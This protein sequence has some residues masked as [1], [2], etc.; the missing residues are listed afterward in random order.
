MHRTAVIVLF[1]GFYVRRDILM[2]CLHMLCCLVV[3]TVISVISTVILSMLLYVDS[4]AFSSLSW[5]I[6][7]IVLLIILPLLQCI[8][9]QSLV[10]EDCEQRFCWGIMASAVPVRFLISDKSGARSFLF[11]SQV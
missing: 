9:Y 11:M 5:T 6:I 7:P 2:G 8:M 10:R 4:V 1:L 3:S